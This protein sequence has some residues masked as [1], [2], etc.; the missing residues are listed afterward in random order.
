MVWL[1]N[2]FFWAIMLSVSWSVVLVF[3]RIIIAQQN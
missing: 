2:V 1:R 3:Q